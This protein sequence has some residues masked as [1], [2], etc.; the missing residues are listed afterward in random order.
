MA[1]QLPP[2]LKVN[3]FRAIVNFA[4]AFGLIGALIAG[5][6]I[7]LSIFD[8]GIISIGLYGTILLLEYFVQVLCAVLN[9]LDIN[10]IAIRKQMAIGSRSDCE[11]GGLSGSNASIQTAEVAVAVVGYRED[12]QAWRQCLRSLSLQSLRPKCIVGVVDGNE[13]PDLSMADAFMDEFDSAQIIH[14]P[15][16]L[17][18]LHRE[19]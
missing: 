4:L 10:R 12:E 1:L 13:E 9:R 3:P 16:L 5:D 18:D 14:L 11:K 2:P 19:T 7:G 8:L 17:S 6:A 15:L